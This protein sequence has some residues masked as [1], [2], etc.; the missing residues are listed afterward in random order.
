MAEILW[1][2]QGLKKMPFPLVPDSDGFSLS[3]DDCEY[4][5]RGSLDPNK[6]LLSRKDGQKL[7]R[8]D[9]IPQGFLQMGISL[10]LTERKNS[11]IGDYTTHNYLTEDNKY[12]VTEFKVKSYTDKPEQPQHI[13]QQMHH[14]RMHEHIGNDGP[15][16]IQE[17]GK[18]S[19]HLQPFEPIT[20]A[21]IEQHQ[22]Y[23]HH[24]KGQKHGH[25]DENQLDV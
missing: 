13:E 3:A 21:D 24:G 14:T 16:L 8:Q 19:W 25:I 17:L 6:L 22:H 15:G 11:F 7:K 1:V 23:L 12:L 5:I 9:R 2:N 10:A 20:D 4:E 18:R